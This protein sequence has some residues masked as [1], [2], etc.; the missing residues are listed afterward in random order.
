MQHWM[1]NQNFMGEIKVFSQDIGHP[2][3]SSTMTYNQM[4][5]IETRISFDDA[6]THTERWQRDLFTLLSIKL[7]TLHVVGF[8]SRLVTRISQKNVY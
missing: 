5:F 3:Y 2:I 8:P 6:N 7:F 4:S 1:K